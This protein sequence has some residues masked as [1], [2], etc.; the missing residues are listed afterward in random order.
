MGCGVG[1]RRIARR[2]RLARRVPDSVF[3][4]SLPPLGRLD[5]RSRDRAQDRTIE[6]DD[7][8]AAAVEESER[9]RVVVRRAHWA[10]ARS[11]AE[12]ARDCSLR[13]RGREN[14]AR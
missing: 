6:R 7:D 1:C 14:A 11:L 10:E 12:A 13:T 5:L 8:L 4:A 2:A 3:A 9:I